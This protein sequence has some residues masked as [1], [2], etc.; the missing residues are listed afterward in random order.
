MAKHYFHLTNGEDLVVDGVG[1]RTRSRADMWLRA[2]E[3][4]DALMAGVPAYGAWSDWVV[5]VHDAAG[6]QVAVIPVLGPAGVR[7]P[8]HGGVRVPSRQRWDGAEASHA[9]L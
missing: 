8:A 4:S 6:R 7:E 2:R 5:C 1:A 9:H 3:V